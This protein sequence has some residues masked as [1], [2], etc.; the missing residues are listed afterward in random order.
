MRELT[1]KRRL[2]GL[3]LAIDRYNHHVWLH[4]HCVAAAHCYCICG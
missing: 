4:R 1:D 3:V 2:H